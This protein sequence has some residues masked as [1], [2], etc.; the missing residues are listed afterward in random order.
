MTRVWFNRTFSNVRTLFELI[1]RADTAADFT[2]ICTHPEPSFPGFTLAHEH[3]L[4]P[5]ELSDAEYL[6]FCL[7][8]CRTHR[9]DAL[10]PGKAAHLLAEQ[11]DR[12]A[13]NGV[14]VLAVAAPE[15]LDRLHD[16]AQF[17]LAARHCHIPPPETIAFRTAAEFEAAYERLSFSHATLCIKPAQGVNGAGFR[18]IQPG[19]AG[20]DALARDELY[21]IS[22]ACLR[23]RLAVTPPTQTWLLMEYLDGTEYSVDAV[24]DGQR[25]RAL[26]QRAK[27]TGRGYG[28]RLVARADLTQAV[29]EL[30]AQFGLTGLF[31]IQ[32]RAGRHGP[33]L[34]EVNARFAGGI[35]YSGAAGVNL[36]YLALHG[37]IHGFASA[38]Q[39]APQ[40]APEMTVLEVAH[41][42]RHEAAV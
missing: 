41:Y 35:G 34:L 29:N 17:A 16:K 22:L 20:L 18:V 8:F 26:V 4:E 12:F 9:I 3:A 2:L 13:A 6:D 28:Q 5:A 1:R 40:H 33:R 11:R 27:T 7:D 37:M 30:T 31:N 14:R 38:T 15:V 25:V 23:Q 10:W 36:P 21:T 19:N 32:F 42:L 39:T 24:G